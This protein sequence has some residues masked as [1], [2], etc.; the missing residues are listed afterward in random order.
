MNLLQITNLQRPGLDVAELTLAEGECVAVMG[1]SG[2]G[3]TLLLRAIVD[4]DPNTGNVSL[5]GMDR[6][7]MIAPEW[8]R[9]VGYVP[10]ESAW[11]AEYVGDHFADASAAAVL[12]K[13]VGL[14]E[15]TMNWPITR[16]SSGEKQRLALIR[17]LLLEPAV[18]LLDEPTAALDEAAKQRV[19]QLLQDRL[20]QHG[21]AVLLATHELAQAQRLA[22]HIIRIEKGKLGCPALLRAP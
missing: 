20:Q 5:D 9:R 3:K 14:P 12:C 17:A 7:A 21:F 22:D 2:A 10:A 6:R 1:P 8:R 19:E 16:L 13:Q 18:L 4:L 15:D 11:W